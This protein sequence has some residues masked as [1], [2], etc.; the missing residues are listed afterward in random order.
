MASRQTES[1]RRSIH[2]FHGCRRC[3][4]WWD[5][6]CDMRA[7]TVRG[8]IYEHRV[9]SPPPGVWGGGCEAWP[10]LCFCFCRQWRLIVR[11]HEDPWGTPLLG[12]GCLEMRHEE[13]TLHGPFPSPLPSVAPQR[14]QT[15]S[16]KLAV[17]PGSPADHVLP[18]H[19]AQPEAT[20]RC[21]LLSRSPLGAMAAGQPTY[22]SGRAHIL[23]HGAL[24]CHPGLWTYLRVQLN[25]PFPPAPSITVKLQCVCIF[26]EPLCQNKISQIKHNHTASGHRLFVST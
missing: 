18:D 26:L 10:S 11:Q 13:W 21:P 7:S 8:W 6:P 4:W 14:T 16:L 23:A 19:Q 24:Y 25:S 22:R 12:C 3:W 2:L 9:H 20:G 5:L 1:Q 15:S 17:L